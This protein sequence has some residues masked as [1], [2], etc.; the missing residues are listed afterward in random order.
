MIK[1]KITDYILA[2]A[3]SRSALTVSTSVSSTRHPTG[4]VPFSV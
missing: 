3:S 4:V 1:I 2:C